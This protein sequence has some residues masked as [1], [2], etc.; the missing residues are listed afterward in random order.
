MRA[1]RWAIRAVL[2]VVRL[3][4]PNAEHVVGR[5][6]ATTLS[7]ANQAVRKRVEDHLCPRSQVELPH[8]VCPV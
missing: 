6:P 3:P 8:H 5:L 2:E 7:G 1:V 4:Y